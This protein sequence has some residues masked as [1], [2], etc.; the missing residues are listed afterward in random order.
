MDHVT[1]PRPFQGRFGTGGLALATLNLLTC[2]IRKSL[3]PL[4]VECAV[5]QRVERWTCDQQVVSSDNNLGQVV[6]TYVPLSP[7]MQYNLVLAK[8]RWCYAAG[9][10]TASLAESNGGLPPGGWFIVTWGLTAYTPWSAMGPTLDN[11]W[12]WKAFLSPLTT[13]I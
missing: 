1:W 11:D 3:N 4:T 12:V 8:G 7:S 9:K 2:Q 10:V 6:Q 5:A 13:K